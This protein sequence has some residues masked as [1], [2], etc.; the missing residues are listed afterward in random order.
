[1]RCRLELKF[2]NVLQERGSDLSCVKRKSQLFYYVQFVFSMCAYRIYPDGQDLKI[3]RRTILSNTIMKFPFILP[4]SSTAS[5][6]VTSPNIPEYLNN[7]SVYGDLKFPT[8]SFYPLYITSPVCSC[9]SVREVAC[10]V[11]CFYGRRDCQLIFV[12]PLISKWR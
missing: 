4:A 10:E 12:A 2:R 3:F 8:A 6:P 5:N 11:V 1:V 9:L 7:K